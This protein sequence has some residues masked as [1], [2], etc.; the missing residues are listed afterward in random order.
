[1]AH[2][3][4]ED[5]TFSYPNSGFNALESVS[6]EVGAGEFLLV[7]GR[8][9]CRKSTLLRHLKPALAPHGERSGRWSGRK[10][11][12]TIGNYQGKIAEFLP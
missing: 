11:E 7:I 3:K 4:I 1:M 2:I 10:R 5:L 6:L 9:G 8:S 12:G